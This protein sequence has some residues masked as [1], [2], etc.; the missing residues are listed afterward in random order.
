MAG[1]WEVRS[2]RSI[3]PGP[4]CEALRSWI[5]F[6]WSGPEE[7]LHGLAQTNSKVFPSGAF[8]GVFES[9]VLVEFQEGFS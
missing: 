1:G 9:G 5:R 6:P 3:G 8:T 4:Q 7:I 2:L